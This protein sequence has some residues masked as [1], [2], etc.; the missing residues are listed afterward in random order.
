MKYWMIQQQENQKN[1]GTANFMFHLVL[2]KIGIGKMHDLPLKADY[3]KKYFEN[4]DK[5]EYIAKVKWEKAFP[6]DKTVSEVGF[7]GN[8]N[9]VCK[10]T[11]AKWNHTV[12]RL[13]S[14]WGIK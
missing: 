8:Q 13:K 14:I 3:H 6:I 5:M 12:G 4:E 1:R 10:P 11:T 2:G 7:F 9:T